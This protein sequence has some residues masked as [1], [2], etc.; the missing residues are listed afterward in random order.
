MRRFVSH[1]PVFSDSVDPA[2]SNG[3]GHRVTRII[4]L[5][6]TKINDKFNNQIAFFF[7]SNYLSTLHYDANQSMLLQYDS[8]VTLN[9]LLRCL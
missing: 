9:H 5:L 8:R 7:Q 3:I 2:R 6:P 4:P 1:H